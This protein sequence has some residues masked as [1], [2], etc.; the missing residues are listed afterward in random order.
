MKGF[1]KE[2]EANLSSKENDSY[3][4]NGE[5]GR[6]RERERERERDDC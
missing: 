6:E 1:L 2:E 4:S 5:G 3:R